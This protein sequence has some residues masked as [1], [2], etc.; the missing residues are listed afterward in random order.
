MIKLLSPAEKTT[1]AYMVCNLIYRSKKTFNGWSLYNCP[2]KD[3]LSNSGR[4]TGSWKTKPLG[5]TGAG[6]PTLFTVHNPLKS[7][8]FF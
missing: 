2:N 6:Q 5:N 8:K 1:T 3:Q 4:R 7:Y